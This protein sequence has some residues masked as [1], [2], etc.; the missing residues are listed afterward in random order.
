MKANPNRR[1]NRRPDRL[2]PQSGPQRALNRKGG[3]T[4]AEL[5]V[6][7]VILAI[8][9][10]TAIVVYAN[11][12]N[13]IRNIK[14]ANLVY[15]EARFTM[16]RIVKEIRNGSIDYEEYY[17]QTANF[18]LGIGLNKTYGQNYC[19][20]SRQFYSPGP[21][22][23]YG[24]FDD[25]STGERN[26]N[27][28]IPI[29][30]PIQEKLYL[31]DSIGTH[32]TYIQRIQT[33]DD[34]NPPN[35]IGKIAILK[36]DGKD[37]GLNKV[38][39]GP[40]GCSRDQGEGDGLIDTWFCAKGFDC[41]K[42]TPPGDLGP[43]C[44]ESYDIIVDDP[45]TLPDD[46]Y[47]LENSSFVDITPAALDIVSLKFFIT[48]QEDPRKAYSNIDIQIQPHVTVKMIARANPSIAAEF[49]GNVPDIVL[50]S[51]ISTRAQKEII[52][53]CNLQECIDGDMKLCPKNRGV[54]AGAEQECSQGVWQGCDE[55]IYT[56]QAAY[57]ISPVAAGGAGLIVPKK[58]VG[59][60]LVDID[61]APD[62]G[63]D[64][65]D[66]FSASPRTYFENGNNEMGS[67]DSGDPGFDDACKN[68]R[69]HDGVDNDGDG[70]TDS[71]DPNCLVHLCNN[72]YL[73]P[74]EDCIDV[75]GIC[76]FRPA[77][78][79]ET[80]CFDSYD[81][82]CNYDFELTAEENINLGQGADE[83]DQNCIDNFICSNGVLDPQA[84]NSFGPE[85]YDNPSY[86]FEKP[87]S[88]E[89][90]EVCIDIGGVCARTS[91]DFDGLVQSLEEGSE[92]D[93]CKSLGDDDA[94]NTCKRSRCTDGFDNDC[95][96]DTDPGNPP[97]NTTGADEFDVDCLNVI[98]KN[99][100]HDNDLI[101]ASLVDEFPDDDRRYDYLVNY[102]DNAGAD[103][104]LDEACTDIGGVCT[105]LYPKEDEETICN[106]DLDNDCDGVFDGDE[107]IN[108]D[109]DC[110]PDNDDDGFMGLSLDCRAEDK[111]AGDYSPYGIIDCDDT[112]AN[113][114]PWIDVNGNRGN[115]EVG[116]DEL[117]PEVC[118]DASFAGDPIDNNCSFVNAVYLP[119]VGDDGWDHSDPSCCVD[120]DGDGFGIESANLYKGDPVLCSAGFGAL[121]ER[122]QFDC[123]DMNDP[124][125]IAQETH[126]NAMEDTLDKCTDGINNNCRVSAV[127]D[128][129]RF[130]HLDTKAN[131]A[132]AL[133]DETFD[134]ECCEFLPGSTPLTGFTH[135][136]NLEVCDD[137]NSLAGDLSNSDENC[138][139]LTG[140]D[141]YYCMTEDGRFFGDNFTI[142]NILSSESVILSYDGDLVYNPGEFTMNSTDGSGTIISK[143]IPLSKNFPLDPADCADVNSAN[144]GNSNFDVL[145]ADIRIQISN[146]AGVTWCGNDDCDGDFLS[147]SEGDNLNDEIVFTETDD[148]ELRWKIEFITDAVFTQ[149][150]FDYGA[151]NFVCE[152][153]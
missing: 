86:L 133:A 46:L 12:F 65:E 47:D 102:T 109:P 121:P 69:C 67:C 42:V 28:P 41:D 57:N 54:V 20:Y 19:E 90:D 108:S 3:F 10:T 100:W 5:L 8:I 38:D 39:G 96:L 55:E 76:F 80:S 130:D 74:D 115:F 40:A 99:N 60:D 16:E 44:S 63:L 111:T 101:D 95:D 134:P 146:D 51:T 53:E 24:T 147:T 116:T 62:D 118:D 13:S 151:I 139:G 83:Y 33:T 135:N 36:L 98:C 124:I 14:A 106:D 131:P 77:E 149:L 138:N 32:R 103:T 17:N 82:D 30:T 26:E 88:D 110:C 21:D 145:P 49:R 89:L 113:I 122:M 125:E 23:Q 87:V 2:D 68:R 126:P 52:T 37:Y 78:G 137:T 143:N 144:L 94:K 120:M 61:P 35:A 117:N 34:S 91:P 141:D 64:H 45:G 58:L 7:T 92:F 15:E 70:L 71:D 84:P 112:N 75:G 152:G 56:A 72:G 50:E 128:N 142:P 119:A 129:E 66:P 127:T 6:A 85:F 97:P 22:G 140:F 27:A 4:I 104:A 31:I 11:F 153:D 43:G 59:E 107:G 73:D 105:P 148:N 93:S 79:T 136:T 81:N 18:P 29:D 48:P 132:E 123:L 1:P 9:I 114:K 150:V 25:E